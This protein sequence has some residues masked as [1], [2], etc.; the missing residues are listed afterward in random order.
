MTS[1]A[2]SNAQSPTN[3][4]SISDAAESQTD[5]QSKTNAQYAETNAESSTNKQSNK[6]DYVMV[7][8]NIV[9]KRVFSTL[10]LLDPGFE[11]QLFYQGDMSMSR[12]N[13]R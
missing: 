9:S 6:T 12:Q 13:I 8:N 11:V 5:A 1:A 4:E 10:L 2:E 7:V 3:A